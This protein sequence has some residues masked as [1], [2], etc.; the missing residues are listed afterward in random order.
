MSKHN[1]FLDNS[2]MQQS[3]AG[4]VTSLHEFI[5]HRTA[6]LKL[7]QALRRLMASKDF[8][9]VIQEGFLKDNALR[10]LSIA[11]THEDAHAAAMADA[12]AKAA[13]HLKGYLGQILSAADRAEA[14]IDGAKAELK[15]IDEAEKAAIAAANRDESA[16]E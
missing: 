9:L 14:S 7:G 6:D 2:E 1:P 11:A 3:E 15:A 16:A 12:T 4:S 8:N 13:T 5:E 10:S